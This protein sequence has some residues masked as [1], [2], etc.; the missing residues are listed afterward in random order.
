MIGDVSREGSHEPAG[1]EGCIQ[2]DDGGRLAVRGNQIQIERRAEP[3]ERLGR[4]PSG[5]DGDLM[6]GPSN[7]QD[8]RLPASFDLLPR[9]D[10]EIREWWTSRNRAAEKFDA[11]L[12]CRKRRRSGVEVR[13]REA[14][15]HLDQSR[16]GL[17]RPAEL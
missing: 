13:G 1:V 4:L 9:A 16:T 6:P 17:A 15:P 10:C 14:V 2:F 8:N 12:G 3:I 7:S 11:A 5:A